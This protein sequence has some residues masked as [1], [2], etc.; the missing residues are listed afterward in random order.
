MPT[1]FLKWQKSTR[2]IGTHIALLHLISRYASLI[3]MPPSPWYGLS[4]E[5][6]GEVTCGTAV[7]TNWLMSI[8]CHIGATV[9]VLKAQAIDAS[10]VDDPKLELLGSFAADAYMG[11]LRVRKTVYL[12]A[13]YMVIF[14]ER[15]I[16]PEKSWSS[17]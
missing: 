9:Y 15:N 1:A 2:G 4:S 13:S 11:S 5:P 17:F 12:A 14:L 16:T 6:K 7:C 3:V 8:G 10:L